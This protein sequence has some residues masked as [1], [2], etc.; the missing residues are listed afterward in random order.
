M[1]FLSRNEVSTYS[2][3][4]ETQEKFIALEN[5]YLPNLYREAVAKNS[6]SYTK[7]A[8]QYINNM[9]KLIH[10]IYTGVG[11]QGKLQGIDNNWE[12]KYN[13]KELASYVDYPLNDLKKEI[14]ETVANFRLLKQEGL[15]ARTTQLQ[16][17]LFPS[18]M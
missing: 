12:L 3:D 13:L 6:E 15:K 1:T 16:E 18:N 4:H 7:S 10:N 9:K 11:D 8:T 5:K 2:R 14:D 17:P